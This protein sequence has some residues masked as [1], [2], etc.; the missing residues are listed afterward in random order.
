MKYFKEV[1]FNIPKYPSFPKAVI[2]T[3]SK[4]SAPYVFH[5]EDDWL[6]T[7]QVKIKH[8]IEIMNEN[9]NLASLRF[10]KYKIENKD[11]IRMFNAIYD[12][13]KQGF[14]VSLDK[15]RQFG[16]NPCLIRSEFVKESYPRMLDT[17]NPEKQFRYGNKHMN[18][19]IMKWD[20]A[21]YGQPGTKALVVDNGVNWKEG[22]KFKKPD[23]STFLVWEKK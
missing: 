17:I 9:K 3:W 22:N 10:S 6:M 18:D 16:L 8:L 12:Y 14:Y 2:W 4:V 15:R 11:R 21:I 1:D 19:I 5:L 23:K 20:Y 13:N 7:R